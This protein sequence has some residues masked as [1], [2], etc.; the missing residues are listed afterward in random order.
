[1]GHYNWVHKCID[2]NLLLVYSTCSLKCIKYF[3]ILSG[4]TTTICRVNFTL[5]ITN[6]KLAKWRISLNRYLFFLTKYRVGKIFLSSRIFGIAFLEMLHILWIPSSKN[7]DSSSYPNNSNLDKNEKST[8]S[9]LNLHH[10][11]ISVSLAL[12]EI[13]SNRRLLQNSKIHCL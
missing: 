8:L 13:K 10:I 6:F 1:M 12:V 7:S 9:T 4:F 2:S 5:F 3:N 11:S